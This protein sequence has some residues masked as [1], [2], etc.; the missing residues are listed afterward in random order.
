LYLE[1]QESGVLE[2]VALVFGQM[3]E[4]PGVRLRVDLAALTAG[5]YL[6][7]G[8]AL[9]QPPPVFRPLAE[10]PG[11]RLR[12]PL[13]ALTVAEYF[14]DAKGQDVLL[15]VANIFRFVQAGSEVWTLL[16]RMPSAGGDEP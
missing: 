1:M 14:R 16:G 3:D 9:E 8:S 6:L 4:P 13:S 15:F 10:P 12:V 7:D 11:V 2:K 5:G